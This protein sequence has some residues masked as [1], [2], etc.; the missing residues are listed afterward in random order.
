M[1]E[2]TPPQK[3]PS[4]RPNAQT[5]IL[6]GIAIGLALLLVIALAVRA[7]IA[8]QPEPRPARSEAVRR[9][10]SQALGKPRDPGSIAAEDLNASNDE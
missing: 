6:L 4:K 5:V 1:W 7:W 2:V 10:L 8:A 3:P 9:I